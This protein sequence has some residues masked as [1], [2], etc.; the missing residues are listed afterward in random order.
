M[1]TFSAMYKATHLM[2]F[3]LYYEHDSQTNEH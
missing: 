2:P 1:K 3:L